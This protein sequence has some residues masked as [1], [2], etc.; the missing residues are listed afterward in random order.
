MGQ[1]TD[2]KI[3]AWQKAAGIQ[4]ATGS[5]LKQ[6]DRLSELAFE[7]IKLVGLEK[8]G[9][10]DGAG[11]WCGSAPL[12]GTVTEIRELHDQM[13]DPDTCAVCHRRKATVTA[14]SED[15]DGLCDMSV[16]EQCER[17]T[18]LPAAPDRHIMD[19]PIPF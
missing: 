12:D 11:F 4:P 13:N 1:R 19:E 5:R 17:E 3:A 2:T 6:L 7:V 16:C 14:M 15:D 8:S 10:R 9:I 18:R